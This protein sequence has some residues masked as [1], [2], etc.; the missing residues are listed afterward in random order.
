MHLT[1][2][3]LEKY[4]K[5]PRVL[6]VRFCVFFHLLEKE[7]GFQGAMKFVSSL[8]N[9][10][11]CNVEPLNTLIVRRFDVIRN[12]KTKYRYW[13]QEIIFM[14]YV[15][16]ESMYRVAKDF[17]DVK[18]NVLYAQSDVYSIDKFCTNEW[19]AKFDT[20]AMFCGQNYY[21]IE[22]IRFLEIIDDITVI[23]RKWKGI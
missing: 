22:V 8:C 13:R 2:E 5:H 9:A 21:K 14:G 1:E 10:Y 23:I 20:Q 7:Y 19:L 18:P 3:E 6:E 11:H 16:G 17:L 12:S 4:K 15:H